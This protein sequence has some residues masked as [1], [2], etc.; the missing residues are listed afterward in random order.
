MH[1][2]ADLIISGISEGL[3]LG[4]SHLGLLVRRGICHLTGKLR[5]DTGHDALF[6]WIYFKVFNHESTSLE[7]HPDR[8]STLPMIQPY[9]NPPRPQ[10]SAL[11]SVLIN[12]RLDHVLDHG[13]LLE[14]GGFESG[15]QPRN[16]PVDYFSLTGLRITTRARFSSGWVNTSQMRLLDHLRIFR[17]VRHVLRLLIHG[18][19]DGTL[20][21]CVQGRGQ[22][23]LLLRAVVVPRVVSPEFFHADVRVLEIFMQLLPNGSRVDISPKIIRIGCLWLISR[24]ISPI[25]CLGEDL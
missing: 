1:S 22:V 3:W 19:L 7:I 20:N 2:V 6:P 14:L 11:E 10:T 4:R 13:D 25:I 16:N 5:F 12:R 9:L 24:L 23:A 21:R 8:L 18:S 17:L 15:W